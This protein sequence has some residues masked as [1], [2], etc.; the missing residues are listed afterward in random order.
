MTVALT[1]AAVA[2]LAVS[3]VLNRVTRRQLSTAREALAAD[4]TAL[5]AAGRA[6][7]DALR[8]RQDAE[9]R[10][11]GLEGRVEQAQA[12]IRTAQQALDAARQAPVE[13]FH[14]LDRLAP[15]PAQL[16]SVTVVRGPDAPGTPPWTG[17]RIC[18]IAAASRNEA[19]ERVML[20]Y[21]RTAGFDVQ[22]ATPCP[23]FQTAEST[24]P[25]MPKR[26]RG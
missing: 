11:A 20:R 25:R 13:R 1:C 10:H 12:D 18:L 21:P 19:L 7:Q 4:E 23:L 26:Q 15:R 2:L 24:A 5:T 9:Q 8:T 6:L 14:V 3:I 22:A 17:E 16:W